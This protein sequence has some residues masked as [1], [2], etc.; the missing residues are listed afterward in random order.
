MRQSQIF[1]RYSMKIKWIVLDMDGTL[2]DSQKNLP[3]RFFELK[4]QLEKLGIKFILASG[5]QYARM[6][7]VVSPLEDDFIYISDNGSI[8]YENR[9]RILGV[10]IDDQ[11]SQQIIQTSYDKMNV[12][13]VINSLAGAHFLKNIDQ[14]IETV[15]NEFYSQRFFVDNFDD[16][17]DIVKISFYHEDDNFDGSEHLN[18]YHDQVNITHSGPTWLD[19]VDKDISKGIALTTIA[20]SHNVDLSSVIVFGDAMNDADMLAVAGFPIIMEN[21][22][23]RLKDLGYYET[24]SNDE[25]GVVLV[26]EKLV[27][28]NGDGSWLKK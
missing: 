6:R 4:E 21:A 1:G 9:E 12:H 3:L 22:D 17:K 14:K 11:L 8:V 10:T 28:K 20:K 16:I 7:E 2:L 24:K 25:D 23:K 15:F 18:K 13:Y 5:R 19:V 27:E 26:L